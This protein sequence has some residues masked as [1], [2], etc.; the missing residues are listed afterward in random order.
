M[1]AQAIAMSTPATNT[2]R[3]KWLAAFQRATTGRIVVYRTPHYGIYHVTS[4]SQPGVEYTVSSTGAAWHE[5]ACTCAAG[6]NGRICLHQAATV[7]ARRHHV[8]AVR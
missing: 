4:A 1:V 3:D 7:F 8:F 2:P 5:L 6:R